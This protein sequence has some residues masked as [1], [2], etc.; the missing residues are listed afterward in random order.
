[1]VDKKMSKLALTK[2]KKMYYVEVN[3]EKKDFSHDTLV[4][5]QYKNVVT[6]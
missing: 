6:R 2:G 1:M 3:V 5:E 4:I